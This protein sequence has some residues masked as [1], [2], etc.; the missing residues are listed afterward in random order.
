M[1]TFATIFH[2]QFIFFIDGLNFKA[3]YLFYPETPSNKYAIRQCIRKSSVCPTGEAER[4]R[5]VLWGEFAKTGFE[6]TER[7][8]RSKLLPQNNERKPPR[9]ANTDR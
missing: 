9:I 1:K 4:G 8:T 6:A 3:I 7:R 2:S 5:V